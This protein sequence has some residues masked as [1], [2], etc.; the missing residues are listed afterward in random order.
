MA[1][2]RC[3]ELGETELRDGLRILLRLGPH[4]YA[5]RLT[6]ESPPDV[7]GVVIDRE[8]GSK[9]H[10]FSRQQLLRDAVSSYKQY[11]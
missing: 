10:I 6:A 11:Q 1:G 4:F 8:R 9:P 2:R 3:C 7:Y 5:G